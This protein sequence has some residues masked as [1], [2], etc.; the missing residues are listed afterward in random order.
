MTFENM[1]FL[2][3]AFKEQQCKLLVVTMFFL[4]PGRL[5]RYSQT[6]IVPHHNE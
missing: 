1:K 6:S 5:Q 2:R 3:L 4:V